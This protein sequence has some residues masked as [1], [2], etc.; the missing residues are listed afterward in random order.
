VIEYKQAFLLFQACS[1]F[2]DPFRTAVPSLEI[3][4]ALLGVDLA[5]VGI[6]GL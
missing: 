5:F 6:G 2:A 3:P 4:R 1:S